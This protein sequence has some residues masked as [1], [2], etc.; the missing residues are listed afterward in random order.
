MNNEIENLKKE[1]IKLKLINTSLQ[2]TIKQLNESNDTALI[3]NSTSNND[4]DTE[5]MSII[6]D[7]KKKNHSLTLKINELN[8]EFVNIVTLSDNVLKNNNNLNDLMNDLI[9]FLLKNTTTN[10]NNEKNINFLIEAKSLNSDFISSK[11][12]YISKFI[13]N[14]F[15]IIM[16]NENSLLEN[17]NNLTFNFNKLILLQEKLKETI[18]KEKKLINNIQISNNINDYIWD[19]ELKIT[20]NSSLFEKLTQHLFLHLSKIFTI[21]EKILQ[22]KSII[23]CKKKLSIISLSIEQSNNDNTPDFSMI[24]T[25]LESLYNFIEN[26][27]ES[28]ID[29]YTNL[30][31]SHNNHN[32]LIPS[33]S[34]DPESVIALKNRIKEIEKNWKSEKERRL[35]DET[36]FNSRINNLEIENKNLKIALQNERLRK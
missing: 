9:N 10:N 8:N 22:E 26:A 4:N 30:I 11:F 17:F 3:Q 16:T 6:D 23:Q 27:L 33:P 12:N 19:L 36:N 28:I 21:L 29:S 25:K 14:Y 2:Q 1:N 15:S 7:L 32:T 18:Y 5:D 34:S 20:Q 13:I 24:Q 35:L 31:V